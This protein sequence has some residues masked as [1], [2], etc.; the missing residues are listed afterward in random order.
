MQDGGLT[1]AFLALWFLQELPRL[2][3]SECSDKISMQDEKQSD[4][5]AGELMRARK[6]DE[7]IFQGR[8]SEK[9]AAKSAARPQ[10]CAD[11]HRGVACCGKLNFELFTRSWRRC[12]RP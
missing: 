6:P 4:N 2:R 12:W 3:I 9:V 7:M 11:E 5:W 10:E 8:D 1:V